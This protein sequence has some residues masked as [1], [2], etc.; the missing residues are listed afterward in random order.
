MS[1][2]E[3]KL[4]ELIEA[5]CNCEGQRLNGRARELANELREALLA[6]PQQAPPSLC[7]V[8]KCL[9]DGRPEDAYCP[10]HGVYAEQPQ[11]VAEKHAALAY[12]GLLK[13][14]LKMDKD[15]FIG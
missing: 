1:E 6:E 10:L 14:G 13:D 12:E 7:A 11:L 9:C 5:L 4:R 15:Y 3:E 2:R 8:L